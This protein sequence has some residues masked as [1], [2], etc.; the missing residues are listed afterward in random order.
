MIGLLLAAAALALQPATPPEEGD[1]IVN[2][3]RDRSEAIKDFVG[4]LT[5]AT[6]DRQLSRFDGREVCPTALGLSP[7]QKEAVVA[8]MRVVAKA[9]GVPLAR[10]RCRPNVFV[11]VTNDKPGLLTTLAKER[12]LYFPKMSKE[13]VSALIDDRSAAVAWQIAGPLLSA[14]GIEM[15]VDKDSGAAINQ[16]FVKGSRIALG[17][18]PQFAGAAVVVDAKALTGLTTTQLADYAAMRAF[19]RTDPSRPELRTAPTILTALDAAPDS[20]VPVTLTEW[21]LKFLK[22]L[23]TTNGNVAA[24]SQRSAIARKLEKK[25]DGKR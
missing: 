5:A 9:A 10:T 6:T 15:P 13:D 24:P 1:V 7:T 20:L 11:L 18:R 14:N 2:G 16:T 22:A 25:L 12:G 8:R 4:A 3:V 21:D 23:Y 19:V 17:S